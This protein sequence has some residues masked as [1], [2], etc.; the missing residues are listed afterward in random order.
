MSALL[1]QLTEPSEGTPPAR[2]I[3]P[4]GVFSPR[5]DTWLLAALLDEKTGLPGSRVLDVC[6]GSGAIGVAAAVRGAEVTAVDVS[7]RSVLTA[8]LN[9]RLN[10]VRVR[11][12]RGDLFD[13]VRG[14]R[15]DTIVSNPPYLPA[16]DDALPVRGEARAWDAGRDGRVLI[17]RIADEAP[18]LLEPDGQ[19]LLIQSSVTGV[20]QT[21]ERLER[22]GFQGVEVVARRRGPL[23]PLLAARA[24][25]LERR[26]LLREGEREEELVAIRAR[27]APAT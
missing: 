2:I 4:P 18:G 12:L 20:P 15:F 25:G 9:A 5:S 11:A 10:G 14:Q 3:A 16:D 6:T 13:P 8:R 17:D 26:G 19:L 7:R 23:G 22:A 1:P 24:D 21:L 27:R